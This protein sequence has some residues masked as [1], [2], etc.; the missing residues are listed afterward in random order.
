MRSDTSNDPARHQCRPSRLVN[1]ASGGFGT[2]QAVR[3]GL[4]SYPQLAAA[5]VAVPVLRQVLVITMLIGARAEADLRPLLEAVPALH[6][7]T[8]DLAEKLTV[9]LHLYDRVVGFWAR[10]HL[11]S[12]FAEHL[13]ADTLAGNTDLA[14]GL[15]TAA[16]TPEQVTH[17][18]MTLARAATHTHTAAVAVQTVLGADPRRL[19]PIAI[20]LARAGAGPIDHAIANVIDRADLDADTAADLLNQVPRDTRILMHT[21]VAVA[22]V[23]VERTTTEAHRA[24]TLTILADALYQIGLHSEAITAA[25]E[26]VN[27]YR[28]L[29]A[30]DPGGRCDQLAKALGELSYVLRRAGRHGEAVTAAGEAVDICRQLAIADPDAYQGPLAAILLALAGSL[31]RAG[32]LREAINAAN[33]AVELCRN[34]AAA[35][36]EAHEPYLQ[37]HLAD[38]LIMLADIRRMDALWRDEVPGEA[39][40]AADE[41]VNIYRRLVA[42]DPDAHQRYLAEALPTLAD[43]LRRAGRHTEAITAAGEAVQLRRRWVA[44]DPDAH[45][46][47][48]IEALIALADA[49]GEAGRHGEALVYAGEAVDVC[50]RLAVADPDAYEPYFA[51]ALAILAIALARAGRRVEAVTTAGEA[52]KHYRHLIAT[53]HNEI[54][55]RNL[56]ATEQI[57][58]SLSH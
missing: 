48:L 44:F 15:I 31:R 29:A 19:L 7:A 13:T 57:I 39:V 23:T 55:K 35:D 33:E 26:A 9:W 6:Y 36:P 24:D 12:V 20:R 46:R 18:L 54:Y 56:A 42:T 8:P 28:R 17:V 52:G 16:A 50:S 37:R 45:Q 43:A 30:A 4:N 11:P 10:P 51:N 3:H 22:R 49:L 53:N 58:R 40:A 2:R 34:G 21:R 47:Y 38:A 1:H 25:G 5:E 32:R 27:I 41:A 14:A